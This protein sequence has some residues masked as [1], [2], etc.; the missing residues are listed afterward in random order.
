MAV[1]QDAN[2]SSAEHARKGLMLGTRTPIG[3]AGARVRKRSNVEALAVGRPAAKADRAGRVALLQR[4][5]VHRARVYGFRPCGLGYD[6][7]VSDLALLLLVILGAVLL[8][9]GP[10]VLP[11]LGASLG[12]G[13]REV[14]S[15]ANHRMDEPDEEAAPPATPPVTPPRP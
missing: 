15:A 12:R 2:D 10:R 8:F 13:V 11:R 6:G 14:R 1:H 3:H 4:E 5:F 9:R 7:T